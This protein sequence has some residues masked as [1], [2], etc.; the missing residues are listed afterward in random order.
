MSEV[1]RRD[2]IKYTS[3]GLAAGAAWMD[4]RRAF[5]A[6]Q[7]SRESGAPLDWATEVTG[8]PWDM[9]SKGDIRLATGG[10]KLVKLESGVATFPRRAGPVYLS[11]R[12][13]LLDGNRYNKVKVRARAESPVKVQVTYL[14]ALNP[15]YPSARRV[16]SAPEQLGTEWKTVELD[17]PID[18][19]GARTHAAAGIVQEI[20]LV[21]SG[22]RDERIE[23]DWVQVLRDETVPSQAAA[24]P[25]FQEYRHTRD[26]LPELDLSFVEKPLF[27]YAVFT[28]PHFSSSEGPRER[29]QKEMV[30]QINALGPDFV[31]DLGD[32]ITVS[33]WSAAYRGSGEMAKRILGELKMPLYYVPGNH[34]VGNKPSFVL[35]KK[36]GFGNRGLTDKTIDEYEKLF[37]APTYHSFDHKGCHVTYIDTMGLGSNTSDGDPQ[38]EWLEKDLASAQDRRFRFLFAH[39]HPMYKDLDEPEE[40]NYDAIDQPYRRELLEL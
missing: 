27:T 19:A 39:V 10:M 26:P 30:R 28:D 13:Q 21:F 31:L 4:G 33:P 14:S 20:G 7:S 8:N 25:P 16:T 3:F 6:D 29:K 22:Q 15:H 34:D 5:G 40:I 9:S 23:L 24:P 17:L 12:G 35:N 2:F 11:L 36:E 38:M 1:T 32:T 18:R 37:D